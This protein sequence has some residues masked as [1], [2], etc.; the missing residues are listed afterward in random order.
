MADKEGNV[1]A[2]S[3]EGSAKKIDNPKAV[4]DPHSLYRSR[5]YPTV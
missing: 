2:L 4:S 3:G 1:G 5:V